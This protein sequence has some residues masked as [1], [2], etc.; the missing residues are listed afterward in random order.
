MRRDALARSVSE[1]PWL[2]AGVAV[3]GVATLWADGGWR[4]TF[5]LASYAAIVLAAVRGGVRWA[6]ICASI[7]A[8]G[9]VSGLVVNGYSWDELVRLHDADSIVANTGGYFIAAYFMAA[10]V[11]WLGGYVPGC[12]AS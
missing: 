1:Q 5:Y 6:L 7:C 8:A 2:L 10:P 12:R 3:I 4:S 9:Y 11:A